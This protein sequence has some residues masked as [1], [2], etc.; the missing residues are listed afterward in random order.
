MNSHCVF[1]RELSGSRDT[2]F[3]RLYPEVDNRIIAETNNLV[4]FPCIGQLSPGHYLIAT[5]KHHPKFADFLKDE[6]SKR[7]ELTHIIESTHQKL[8]YSKAQSLYFEHGAA[9]QTDGGCGIYHAHLHIVPNAGNI[10]ISELPVKTSR[11]FN[12]LEEC[13]S[14][15]DK[16]TPYAL[17]GSEQHGYNYSTLTTPLPSQTLR[18]KVSSAMSVE[19][20]DWQI[21]GREE[22]LLKM[23]NRVR[24]A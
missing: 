8:G 24:S 12:R 7:E 18:K 4:A 19:I 3:A 2:N 5:K 15:I 1:C 11:I 16:E 20:W 6:S 13:Y 22:H 9:S 10:V 21:A 17:F 14:N 23:L